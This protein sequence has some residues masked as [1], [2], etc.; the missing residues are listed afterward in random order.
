MKKIFCFYWLFLLASYLGY[1]V[2]MIW[3]F[4]KYRKIESRKSLIYE[5]MIPIYG[6]SAILIV[7]IVKF[8]E[9]TEWYFIFIVGFIICS[10]VEFLASL[11]QEKIFKTKSWDYSDYPLNFKGRINVMYSIMFGLVALLSYEFIL[12]PLY[13]L[14]IDKEITSAFI[15]LTITMFIFMIYDFIISVLAVYRMKERRYGVCRNHLFWRFIDNR[16]P[17]KRLKKIYANM[18]EI[19]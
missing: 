10:M 6:L 3:C 19:N 15:V 16:Y 2:E 14:L 13:N 8:L 18:V 17:D 1:I 5:P 9:I 12:N 7:I 11:L 4:I